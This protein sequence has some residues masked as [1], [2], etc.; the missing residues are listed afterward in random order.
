MM[1]S[2]DVRRPPFE[3]RCLGPVS[4]HCADG[5]K[6][7]FRTRKQMALFTFLLRRQ[8]QAQPRDQLTDLLWSE[9]DVSRARHSLSQ[10][11]SLI[12]KM[13]GAEVVT[14]P[15]KDELLLREGVIWSD[16]V[17]FE[18]CAAQH[19]QRDA[20]ALWRGNLLE[21]IWIH[22]A[23]GFERWLEAERRRLLET[24]RRALHELIGI[25]RTEGDWEQM[26]SVAESLLEL[27]PLDETAM[28]AQ[29]VALTLLGDRTLALRRYSAFE[30]RLHEE[31]GAEPGPEMRAWA[32]RQR[33]G[34]RSGDRA[35][36]SGGRI[37]SPTRPEDSARSPSRCTGA[38][39]SSR[40]S[41]RP[42]MRPGAARA[43][44]SCCSA[45]RASARA[46][47]PRSWWTRCA[48]PAARRAS[49]AAFPPSGAFRSR[50]SRR[51]C[52][53]WPSYRGSSRSARSGSAS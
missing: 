52:A 4:L 32:M 13:L 33:S 27:D 44:A 1:P 50:R 23:P 18:H 31:L 11:T 51:W 7:G 46:P 26:R 48:W 36:S 25:A 34:A 41:G 10:T 16:V 9:D 37:N 2:E 29:L 19:R 39:P 28:L 20:R 24:M 12:N 17:E 15:A 8:G 30:T 42:G 40:G 14:I 3:F 47:W 21:G 49:R 5:R 43:G 35:E 6:L 53:R 45:P 22:N 38:R